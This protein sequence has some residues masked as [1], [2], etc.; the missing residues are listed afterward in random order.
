MKE[1]RVIYFFKLLIQEC[2]K[3]YLI[4]R[5]NTQNFTMYIIQALKLISI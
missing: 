5:L 2:R 1:N 3:Q 4:Y